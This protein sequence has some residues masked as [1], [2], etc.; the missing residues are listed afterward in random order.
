MDTAEEFNFSDPQFLEAVRK[1]LARGQ[2]KETSPADEETPEGEAA[3]RIQ[4][5]ILLQMQKR[6]A[7]R[8]G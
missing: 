7:K 2:P 4:Y 1:L 3:H 8:Q 5:R 6:N